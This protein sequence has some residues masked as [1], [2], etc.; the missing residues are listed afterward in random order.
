[1]HDSLIR[2]RSAELVVGLLASALASAL[3]LPVGASL[4]AASEAGALVG[5]FAVI[6]MMEGGLCSALLLMSV[7][8]QEAGER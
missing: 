3:A 4:Q 7:R 6:L 8:K 1:M 2:P 5:V